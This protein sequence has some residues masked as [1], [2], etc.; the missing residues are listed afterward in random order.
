MVSLWRHHI[1]SIFGR[2]S[3][4]SCGSDLYPSIGVFAS[5]VGGLADI[6]ILNRW[7]LKQL[8]HHIAEQ[9][10]FNRKSH[11]IAKDVVVH[12]PALRAPN[13]CVFGQP[14][15]AFLQ[16]VLQLDR[17]LN[18]RPC[19]HLRWMTLF[20]LLAG[21]HVVIDFLVIYDHFAIRKVVFAGCKHDCKSNV[22]VSFDTWIE[23][24]SG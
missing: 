12:C 2:K 17:F 13:H 20:N 19:N 11:R 10:R 22:Q 15:E 24:H 18:Q 14:K 3:L 7:I 8:I 4:P 16:P 5:C 1:T 6:A 9:D 21:R 23:R